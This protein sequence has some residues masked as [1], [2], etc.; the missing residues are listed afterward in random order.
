MLYN[1]LNL[2][3][4]KIADT[5]NA[6]KAVLRSVFFTPN[7]T[8]ATDSYRLIEV[9]V[10]N[11]VNVKDFPDNNIMRGC[12]SFMVESRDI[13]N[14]KLKPNKSL[15]ILSYMALTHLDNKKVKFIFRPDVSATAE[16]SLDRIDDRF[17]EYEKLM[18]QG[19][20][21]VEVSFNAEYLSSLLDILGQ[22]KK[23]HDVTLKIYADDK[24]I[25]LEAHNDSQKGRA[26]LMPI[27][28]G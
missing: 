22:F 24:P 2:S 26:M 4:A 10:D 23:T 6:N 12:S 14:I 9:S 28:K 17:P 19:K 1:N 3:V 16:P 13:K 15:P 21:K 25:I 5:N 20:P 11:S 27:R 18:S 8:V 7:K